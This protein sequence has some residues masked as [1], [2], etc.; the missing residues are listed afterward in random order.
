MLSEEELKGVPVLVFANK[1]VSH[2]S[3]HCL[4]VQGM[5]ETVRSGAMLTLSPLPMMKDVPGALPSGEISDRLG[6]AGGE[7]SR[8]WSVRGSCALKGEG[9]EE[10]RQD[11][12]RDSVGGSRHVKLTDDRP[13]DHVL[14][15]GLDWLSNIITSK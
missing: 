12:T 6:L 14:F 3:R 5:S 15:Q 10:V 11:P 13:M 2:L 9:L 4:R 8:E 7:K 1:Q